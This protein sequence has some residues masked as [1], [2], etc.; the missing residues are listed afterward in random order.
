MGSRKVEVVTARAVTRALE[1]E[2]DVDAVAAELAALAG[3]SWPVLTAALLRVDRAL[4]ERWSH[5]AA[6]ASDALRLAIVRVER[7]HLAAA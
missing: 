2:F 3:N 7:E 5:V 1:P 6:D 4:T